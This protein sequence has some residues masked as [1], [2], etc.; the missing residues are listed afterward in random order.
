MCMVCMYNSYSSFVYHLSYYASYIL[1]LFRFPRFAQWLATS[2]P[3]G[4]GQNYDD[5]SYKKTMIAIALYDACNIYTHALSKIS[6]IILLI[7]NMST[8]TNMSTSTSTIQR[9]DKSTT[10]STI[11]TADE[12]LGTQ[13]EAEKSGTNIAEAQFS[14]VNSADNKS[15]SN[16]ADNNNDNNNNNN[17]KLAYTSDDTLLHSSTNEQSSLHTMLDYMKMVSIHINLYIS[18]CL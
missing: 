8:H 13:A 2:V 7:S 6:N 15:N 12:K 9:H 10:T 4:K 14:C 11:I 17:N 18:V 3:V 16:D 5:L 1:Y